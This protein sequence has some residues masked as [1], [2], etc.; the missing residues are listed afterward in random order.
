MKN[1]KEILFVDDV[2]EI[3]EVF[4]TLVEARCPVSVTTCISAV[5]ALRYLEHKEFDLLVTDIVMPGMDG[6]ELTNIVI[7]AYDMPVILT[8][9]YNLDNLPTGYA[10]LDAVCCLG[11]PYTV[12]EIEEKI[13]EAFRRKKLK[14]AKKAKEKEE[15]KKEPE[16]SKLSKQVDKC[17]RDGSMGRGS[18]SFRLP[19]LQFG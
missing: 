16:K 11:K 8:T 18:V 7:D 2:R 12:T 15:V 17:L 13:K 14:D 5:Q 10:E 3:G 6:I 1:V 4:K 19:E 9:G